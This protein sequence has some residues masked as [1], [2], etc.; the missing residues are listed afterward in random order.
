MFNKLPAGIALVAVILFAAPNAAAS[1]AVCDQYPDI[2]QCAAPAT[3]QGGTAAQPGGGD[4]TGESVLTSG[5]SPPAAEGAA[6][7]GSSGGP[8]KAGDLPFTGYP[9]SP[10][11]AVLLA[12]LAAG[13]AIRIY[14]AVRRRFVPTAGDR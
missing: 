12:A 1:S 8:G 13:L 3:G 11:V 4:G 2:P 9:L 10:L 7:A 6:T 5:G 14:L